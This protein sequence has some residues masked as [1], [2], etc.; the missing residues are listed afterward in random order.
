[1][2]S[3]VLVAWR[4]VSLLPLLADIN[5]LVILPAT[6]GPVCSLVEIM[7]SGPSDPDYF[8]SHWWVNIL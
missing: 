7:G 3:F 8:V 4:W 1:M 6:E 5:A 2:A